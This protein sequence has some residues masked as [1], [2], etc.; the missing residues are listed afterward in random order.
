[1]R[2]QLVLLGGL[3]AGVLAGQ[4]APA[5]AAMVEVCTGPQ[6]TTCVALNMGGSS[7]G[8]GF[9][10][11]VPL[12]ILDQIPNFPN[13]YVNGVTGSITAGKLHVWTGTRGGV[14]TIIRYSATGSSD[15]V[16]KLQQFVA[17]AASNMTH[18]DHTSA[19]GCNAAVLLTRP[20]DGKQYYEVTD[21]TATTVQ[22]STLGASDVHGAS[23]HQVGPI[24]AIVKPLDQSMLTSVQAAI[25]PFKFVLGAGVRRNVGGVLVNVD[26]L[27]RTEIE[28]LLS[29]NVTKWSQIGLV[30]DDDL[31]NVADAPEPDLTL[32]L[33]R[34][35]S[36]TKAALDETVMKDVTEISAGS[37][38]LTNSAPGVY[39]GTSTQD[40]Q[41]CVRG[42]TDFAP[43]RPAHKLAIGYL[44]ADANVGATGTSI[45]PGYDV[46]LN[47]LL[48][49]DPS[50]T[51]P[52]VNLKCGKYLY[53]V[54]WRLNYRTA[55]DPGISASQDAL[56]QAFVTDAQNP[57]TIALLPAGAFWLAPV[58]MYVFK[59]TDAGPI[60]W[61]PGAHPCS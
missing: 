3:L 44:D 5:A 60:Q 41:D 12:N 52:K 13:H 22:P 45:T 30:A 37:S 15:G 32:C 11:Q 47:G 61:K 53:W 8:T 56:I 36:G 17:N 57:A 14:P 10:T 29:R 27:T 28:G 9:A 1:M 2:T 55:D 4:A 23:F 38:S 24:T 46:K 40:V 48:A 21:C 39:F 43:I 35:G 58:D 49:N 34:A 25:V 20:S 31:N 42:N 59:N 51:D 54:G 50:L 6:P 18:L 7:A 26:S 33:R 16:L 19:A